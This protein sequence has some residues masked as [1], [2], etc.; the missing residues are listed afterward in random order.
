MVGEEVGEWVAAP[1]HLVL[2]ADPTA[3][4]EGTVAGNIVGGSIVVVARL[5]RSLYPL[6][7]THSLCTKH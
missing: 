5:D 7:F 1:V 3:I 6:L 4:A 2:F